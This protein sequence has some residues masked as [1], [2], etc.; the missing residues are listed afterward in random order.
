MGLNTLK[1]ASES[2]DL[3]GD[4]Q[5]AWLDCLH[6]QSGTFS[7]VWSN[8]STL[9]GEVKVEAANATDQSDAQVVTL[10][11]TLGVSGA[12]GTHMAHLESLPGRFVRLTYTSSAGTGDAL[13]YFVGKGDAN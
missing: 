9:T 6:M 2:L 10:S 11:T 8:G 7:F 4:D 5:S 1:P 13:V 12:S 3:S